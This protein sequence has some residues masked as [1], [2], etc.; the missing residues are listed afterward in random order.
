M[1][2]GRLI[3]S[4]ITCAGW[5]RE[6]QSALKSLNGVSNARVAAGSGEAE[7][8]FDEKRDLAG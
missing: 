4:G 3:V 1:R 5:A 6:L 8:V 2:T 7:V